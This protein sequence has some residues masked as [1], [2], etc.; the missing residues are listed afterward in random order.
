MTM[1]IIVSAGSLESVLTSC[2]CGEL[3]GEHEYETV[4]AALSALIA[5]GA[6]D[7]A[8]AELLDG[9]GEVYGVWSSDEAYDADRDGTDQLATIRDAETA[10]ELAAR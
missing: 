7:D 6:P 9:E 4:E 3:I 10:R 1:Y 2:C 5:V 8:V